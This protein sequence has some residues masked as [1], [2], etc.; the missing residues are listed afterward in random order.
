MC[1]NKLNIYELTLNI[2]TTDENSSISVVSNSELIQ[3]WKLEVT[4]HGR[5]NPSYIIINAKVWVYG[6]L[7]VTHPATTISIKLDNLDRR[8]NFLV[9]KTIVNNL[10][11]LA[12]SVSNY[13][14]KEAIINQCI[15]A[16]NRYVTGL[17]DSV[18]DCPSTYSIN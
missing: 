17:T 16:Y 10:L 11:I 6:C 4:S 2:Q 14:V 12:L 13:L 3:N 15:Y 9:C 1:F 18:T 8:E 7:F 5:D